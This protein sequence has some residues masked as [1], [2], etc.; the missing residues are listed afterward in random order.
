MRR[1]G[2]ALLSLPQMP[3]LPSPSE[4]RGR[5]Q[6]TFFSCLHE[7]H[8]TSRSITCRNSMETLMIE[9]VSETVSAHENAA[10]TC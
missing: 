9:T 6:L 7:I 10:M 1:R 4:I 3:T 5:L 8:R 2:T